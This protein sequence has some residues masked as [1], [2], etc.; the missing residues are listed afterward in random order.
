MDKKGKLFKH[1]E[2]NL[3]TVLSITVMLVVVTGMI[4]RRTN[5]AVNAV[6]QNY[7]NYIF[8]CSSILCL[9]ICFKDNS[10]MGIDI[11]SSKFTGGLKKGMKMLIDVVMFVSAVLAVVYG[12]LAVFD[13]AKANPGAF[14]PKGIAYIAL[15]VVMA[16]EVVRRLQ[17]WFGSKEKEE[18]KV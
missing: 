9:T 10:Y 11:F 6:L 8:A 3:A 18:E 4:L 17:V 12:G 14:L 13:Y 15:P 1:L 16:I 2:E 7:N 5:P